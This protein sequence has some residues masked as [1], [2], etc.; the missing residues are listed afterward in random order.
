MK[1]SITILLTLAVISI[2][3]SGSCYVMKPIIIYHLKQCDIINCKTCDFAP[4]VCDN[5]Y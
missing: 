4:S 3:P 5:C 2:I 1:T